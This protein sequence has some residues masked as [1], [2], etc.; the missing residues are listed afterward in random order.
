MKKL[1]RTLIA[2]LWS[3]FA[4]KAMAD[5]PQGFRSTILLLGFA[6]PFLLSGPIRAVSSLSLPLSLALSL[7]VCSVATVALWPWLRASAAGLRSPRAWLWE[8]LGLLPVGFAIW[9]LYNRDF[10]GFMNLDGWDGG[11]HVFIKDQFATIA[12]NIYNGQVSYYAFMWWLER[13]FQVDS[14]RSSAIAFYVAVVAT[15]AFPLGISFALIHRS[16]TQDRPAR[17]AATSLALL[18]FVGVMQAVVLPLLHYN[19]AA[20][21]YVHVFGLVPLMVLW[22]TDA[23]IQQRALRIPVLLCAFVFLRY[24]YSLNLADAALALAAIVIIER[25]SGWWRIAQAMLVLG[26]AVVAAKIIPE[27]L[28]I[29]R[30]WGGMQRFDVDKVLTADLLLAGG[31]LLYAI[32]G[33]RKGLPWIWLDSPL[34]RAIRFPVFFSIGSSVLFSHFRHGKGVQYYYVTKYQMWACMLLAFA[35]VI[36]VAHLSLSL[37]RW[38]CLR[39]PTVWLQTTLVAVLLATV[40]SQWMKTFAGYR[41]TLQERMRPHGPPYKYL[42]PLADVEAIT[43]IKSVLSSN[44]KQ[45]GGYLT[46]FYPMFSFMNGVLG[47]HAGR[48]EFFPPAIEPGYCVFWISRE[49]DLYRLGPADKLDALRNQVAA[50]GSA[51]SEYRVPWK[52]TPQSLCQRCY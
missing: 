18:G 40:P 44:H 8:V 38:S 35:L 33:S 47:R 15:I 9:A 13:I 26:L 25:F 3:G 24:T 39:K 20:G 28:P 43:R 1:L 5:G 34:F 4:P 42:F 14:F 16:D 32:V 2:R 49:R 17:V 12:P 51:C 50:A 36:V 29:L 27:I 52:T 11:S 31:T 6:A 22:A 23:L 10:G 45:F 37:V 19:Q 30:L 21:Y 48:Q 7:V 46:A 41:T